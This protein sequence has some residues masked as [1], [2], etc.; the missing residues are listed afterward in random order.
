MLTFEKI[1]LFYDKKL[2]TKQMVWDSV[3]CPK[4]K[5]TKEQYEEITGEKYEDE[6]PL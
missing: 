4:P 6:R 5:I 2:W 1:K 3:N